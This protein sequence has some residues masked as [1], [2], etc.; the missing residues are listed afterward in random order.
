MT[1]AAKSDREPASVSHQVM[2]VAPTVEHPLPAALGVCRVIHGFLSPAECAEHIAAAERRGFSSAETDYPPSYR[3][4]ARQV[5]DDVA[6]AQNLFQRLRPFVPD[7]LFSAPDGAPTWT[8]AGLNERIR[9]C[10]YQPGERFNI[11]QD[12]VHHRD[13]GQQSR[14]TFMIYLTDGEE[15]EGGDTVFFASGPGSRTDA[16]CPEIIARVRPRRGTL[17]LFDHG[18]WHAGETVTRGVKHLLRSDLLYRRTTPAF[19]ECKPA[20]FSGTHRGYVWSLARLHDNRV[21]SCGRDGRVVIW[22]T[23]GMNPVV[24]NGH[25]QSVLGLAEPRPGTLASISRDRTLRLW[26]LETRV[27]TAT[28]AAHSAAVLSL[29]A[30]PDG[31]LATGAADQEIRL[32]TGDGAP[33]GAL[34]GHSGWVWSLASALTGMLVSASEDGSLRFWNLTDRSCLAAEQFGGPLRAIDTRAVPSS[35]DGLMLALGDAEGWIR[36]LRW[37]GLRCTLSTSFRAHHAAVRRVRFLRDG[38]L[39]SCGED[40]L[41]RRWSMPDCLI[42]DQRQHEN[43]VTD[44]AELADGRLLTSGYDG[45][46]LA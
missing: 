18:I 30:L 41:M 6:M 9:L 19:S 37:D 36:L 25:E 34:H 7:S 38:S 39:A 17:I 31:N 24:L 21:A 26:D 43:F 10:R 22:D 16:P 42:I 27:C 12:G 45:C 11:H 33:L 44:I 8:L 29:V 32:W 23:D 35:E 1:G 4:N 28:V 2:P 13:D 46:R 15:F 5:V 40:N 14:L 3:N 20:A